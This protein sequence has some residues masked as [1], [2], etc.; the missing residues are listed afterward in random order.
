MLHRPY[1]GRCWT[2]QELALAR[3]AILLLGDTFITWESFLR[4]L[5]FLIRYT[6]K[7]SE[8]ISFEAKTALQRAYN[9][10]PHLIA[11]LRMRRRIIEN[12]D[13]FPRLSKDDVE[14]CRIT[15][16]VIQKIVFLQATDARDKIF[17]FHGI[18]ITK[19]LVPDYIKD[20]LSIYCEFARHLTLSQDSCYI[21]WKLS[22]IGHY[23]TVNTINT[24][25]STSTINHHSLLGDRLGKLVVER[26]HLS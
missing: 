23:S 4:F 10:G 5:R 20:T 6:Q 13:Q 24:T 21:I 3:D 17:A 7:S 25:T 8:R 2:I 9:A 1:W 18:G 14:Y 12:P 15:E 26:N 11:D 16:A 19:H 22:G